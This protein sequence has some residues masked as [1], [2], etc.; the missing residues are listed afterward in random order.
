MEAMKHFSLG[1]E[2]Q[3]LPHVPCARSSLLLGIATAASVG[4]IQVVFGR[5]IQRS[6]N[7]AVGTF[8]FLSTVSWFVSG[9]TAGKLVGVPALLSRRACGTSWSNMKSDA[10]RQVRRSTRA[11]ASVRVAGS[12]RST[13][14]GRLVPCQPVAGLGREQ[15]HAPA[16]VHTEGHRCEVAQNKH[17]HLR[18]KR[19]LRRA[20]RRK[21]WMSKRT[22]L[23]SSRPC[24]SAGS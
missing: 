9:L 2:L 1:E 3:R 18:H 5:G 24:P 13:Y 8:L 21:H 16:L 19:V 6:S 10:M 11:W 17:G 7:W 14:H 12:G 15:A 4:M 20:V 22:Y 23:S